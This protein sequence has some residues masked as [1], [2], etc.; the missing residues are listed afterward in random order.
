MGGASAGRATVAAFEVDFAVVFDSG[1][2]AAGAPVA[3]EA[4]GAPVFG[5][6][7]GVEAGAAAGVAAEAAANQVFTPPCFEQAVACVLARV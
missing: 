3:A 2:E 7:A 6:G 4:A 1:V 5:V